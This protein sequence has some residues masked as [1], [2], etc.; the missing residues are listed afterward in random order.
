MHPFYSEDGRR[1]Q[2]RF[3]DYWLKDIDNGVMAEP[4]VKLAIRTGHDLV[5]PALCERQGDQSV[6]AGLGCASRGVR[7]APALPAMLSFADKAGAVQPMRCGLCRTARRR[8]PIERLAGHTWR[9]TIMRLIS[10][11]ALAGLRL[12]GQALAQFMIVWQR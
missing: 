9:S 6:T 3:F 2:L 4:P 5:L 1:D 12:F 10:A 7:R 8:M 11:M